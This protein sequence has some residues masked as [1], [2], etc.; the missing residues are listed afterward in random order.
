MKVIANFEELKGAVV[1]VGKAAKKKAFTPATVKL[2][3]D[4]RN[5]T[6]SVTACGTVDAS[7]KIP[8]QVMEAGSF[9]T[10][11]S[12]INLLSVRKCSGDVH[13]T[14]NENGQLLLKYR[15]SKANTVLPLADSP[16][17]PMPVW[18]EKAEKAILPLDVLKQMAR[19]VIG[20]TEDNASSGLHAV[21]LSIGDDEEEGITKV[22][23][24]GCD[25]KSIAIRTAYA[26]KNGNYAGVVVLLPED[27][28]TAL[29]IIGDSEGEI[30]LVIDGERLFLSH[31]ETLICMNTLSSS[32][33]NVE[34][35]A[36]SRSM[37]FKVRMDKAEFLEALSCAIYLQTEERAKNG[38]E[39]SVMIQ[40]SENEV[41]VRSD[42]ISSYS[43]QLDA[44]TEGVFP[45][46]ML[47]NTRLLKAM[48]SVCP[49]D[50][51]EIG[52]SSAK[53][54]LW[55][56]CGENGEYVYCVLPRMKK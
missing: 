14:S 50:T 39:G 40:F 31:S 55:M 16:L 41:G 13:I 9:V 42:G 10:S 45:G 7:I 8:C 54:P 46:V 44:E 28:K 21:K 32:F 27:L 25:G 35:I 19:D 37:D 56:C 52:G 30:E 49:G 6:V 12:D 20:F 38:T 26:A 4:G 43:E 24:V 17:S 48:A 18:T 3:A 1:S 53:A 23:M 51:L 2:E 11:F 34:A 36:D 22:Q 33:P 29:D 47:F 15:G 5:L